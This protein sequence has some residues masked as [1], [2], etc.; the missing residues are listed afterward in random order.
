MFSA[1]LVERQRVRAHAAGRSLL[2]QYTASWCAPCHAIA[3][4]VVAAT[5]AAAASSRPAPVLMEVDVDQ[6]ADDVGVSSVPTLRLYP[7]DGGGPPFTHVG[8]T[9]VDAWLRAHITA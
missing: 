1:Q 5:T 3:S 7:V 8:T 6:C 4:K 2:V 9:G